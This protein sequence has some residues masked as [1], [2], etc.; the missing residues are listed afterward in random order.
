MQ[1]FYLFTHRYSCLFLVYDSFHNTER[2]RKKKII[3]P[4][5][6]GELLVCM[7]R[8]FLTST[9]KLKWTWSWHNKSIRSSRCVKNENKAILGWNYD[10][11]NCYKKIKQCL[12]ILMISIKNLNFLVFFSLWLA[13]YNFRAVLGTSDQN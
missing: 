4:H 3:F 6:V 9:V 8:R 1:C 13:R 2:G 11:K 12:K 10:G 7:L 5:Q